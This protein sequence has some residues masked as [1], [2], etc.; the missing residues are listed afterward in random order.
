MKEKYTEII[1]DMPNLWESIDYKKLR[2]YTRKCPQSFYGTIAWDQIEHLHILGS[3]NSEQLLGIRGGLERGA[4]INMEHNW[5][6]IIGPSAKQISNY[7]RACGQEL[8]LL[9]I[10]FTDLAK[11]DLRHLTQ[12]KELNLSY[13]EQLLE[14]SGL[15]EL[16]GLTELDLYRTNLREP[17]D[18]R[19][20]LQ[21][22]ILSIAM[23][24]IS[25]ILVDTD[26]PQL[27]YLQA[28]NTR[29]HSLDFL[30]HT[31]S[32]WLLALNRCDIDE[33]PS[34]TYLPQLRYL[35]L[36]HT[37]IDMVPDLAVLKYLERLY[38][39]DTRIVSV[40][41]VQG[42]ENLQILSLSD[43]PIQEIPEGIQALKRLRKLDLS[44]LKLAD[45]PNW[46]PELGLRFNL[47]KSSTGLILEGTTVRGVDTSIF[48]QPHEMVIEW[49]RMR[50]SNASYPLNELKVVFL[51]DGESGKS[52][53]IARL[54]ND[55][56]KPKN[57]D[58]SVTPGIAIHKKTYDIYG[59][60]I[61]INFWDFGGQ[62]I[63]HSMHRIFM[64]PR[65][66]YVVLIN[67]RDNTQDERARYWLHNI[68]SF[69]NE[70]R[71]LMVLNKMDQNPNASINETELCFRFKNLAGVI[72]LSALEAS[73][74]EF[75]ERFTQKLLYEIAAFETLSTAF[76]RP[77]MQ[78]KRELQDMGD[79]YLTGKQ[80]LQLCA[81]YGVHDARTAS[82]L[83]GWFNDLGICFSKKDE[84]V[85]PGMSEKE[86][87]LRIQQQYVLQPEWITNAIYIILF[88]ERESGTNGIIAHS[89]IRSLLGTISGNTK[90]VL[91]NL[92]YTAEETDFVLSVIR[93]FRLSYP[94]GTDSEFMPMLCLRNS[95][96]VAMEY[97]EDPRT[98]EFRMIY[99]Y[100]PNNVIHRLMVERQNEVD[101]N[102]V[103]LTGAL[104]RQV[105]EKEKTK[106]ND[107]FWLTGGL[108]QQDSD[109]K[110]SAVV[111][112]DGNALKINVRSGTHRSAASSYLDSLLEHI[113]RISSE[114]TL[115]IKERQLAH[116]DAGI[117]EYFDYDELKG[118]KM[119]GMEFVYS[120]KQKKPIRIKDI[121]NQ[122]S[123]DDFEERVRLIRH[124][125]NVFAT[126]QINQL[127]WDAPEAIR[128]DYV[129]DMLVNMRYYVCD[130][131][132][133][134]VS[135]CTLRTG[136]LDLDIRKEPNSAWTAL[137][138]L[139]ITGNTPSQ[140]EYWN[141]HLN[142]LLDSSMLCGLEFAVQVCFVE[143]SRERYRQ[144]I[145]TFV[146]HLH[147]YAPN[148][149]ILD[150]NVDNLDT[151]GNYYLNVFRCGYKFDANPVEVYHI[152]VRIG[153]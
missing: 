87:I 28:S 91:P 5:L 29:I 132:R 74:E 10:R 107:Y 105:L 4:Y 151:D 12:L 60:Q 117:V 95:L 70:A 48:N 120:K 84:Q 64:T 68:N 111:R 52:H 16:T 56:G 32:L 110:I 27:G 33:I 134:G 83:L 101:T 55:G 50:Q 7:L 31:P 127:F 86:R 90:R 115:S 2:N 82:A 23:S 136:E 78:I 149:A 152:F 38:L 130:Q 49:F 126:M 61:N 96:P 122:T 92:I 140:I 97:T 15:R 102:H 133:T 24:P 35:M 135:S 34:M 104:F 147:S 89:E 137:E 30:R 62:E 25:E 14:I 150:G 148:G 93:Q 94:F 6:L 73:Q 44:N 138:A 46:L 80:Y 59:N 114:L 11:V 143:N 39:D 124:L 139:N 121:L 71:V 113:E 22:E 18:L 125:Q 69:A 36:S 129:R 142:R 19:G 45:L 58:G 26:L 128:T 51:G 76:P 118:C 108:F 123:G 41:G 79:T 3:S 72:K 40:D 106:D 98:L 146:N 42:L 66:L 131:S 153:S 65:T 109:A 57:Y 43:T 88:N 112:I 103:W 81:Q 144:I 145:R 47:S 100:L 75:N 17:L 119:C 13:N 20:K 85:D 21:L 37:R 8:K 77:W 67:A 9:D 63:L 141:N 116:K 99:D 53:T 1:S 54:M